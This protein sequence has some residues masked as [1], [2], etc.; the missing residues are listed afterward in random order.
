MGEGE[1][2][3]GGMEVQNMKFFIGRH[4]LIK[5]IINCLKFEERG[6]NYK[7][8]CP[9]CT[10]YPITC[11]SLMKASQFSTGC[12]YLCPPKHMISTLQGCLCISI[13]IMLCFDLP[14]LFFCFTSTW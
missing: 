5:S 6:N 9:M 11:S 8:H 7:L 3:G 2:E 1:G 13:S 12:F 14:L 10:R 4:N